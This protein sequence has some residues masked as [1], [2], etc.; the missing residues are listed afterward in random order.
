MGTVSIYNLH[1][2]AAPLH[3][4]YDETG[5][6]TTIVAAS[7]QAIVRPR[8]ASR[9]PETQRELDAT[10]INSINERRLNADGKKAIRQGMRAL[11][12]QRSHRKQDSH[13]TWHHCIRHMDSH[14]GRQSTLLSRGAGARLQPLSPVCRPLALR[15][16]LA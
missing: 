4:G 13:E 3:F 2:V 12:R 8:S 11:E 5:N 9:A 16:F 6:L 1:R 10:V 7:N 15:Y 14:V